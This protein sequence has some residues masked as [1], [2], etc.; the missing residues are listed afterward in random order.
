MQHTCKHAGN[1]YTYMHSYIHTNIHTYK[2]TYIQACMQHAYVHTYRCANI[3]ACC[4]HKSKKSLKHSRICTQI[5]R[6]SN[7]LHTCTKMQ[8]RA[9]EIETEST[10]ELDRYCLSAANLIIPKKTWCSIRRKTHLPTSWLSSRRSTLRALLTT[11]SISS[12]R[13][14]SWRSSTSSAR[15]R[16]LQPRHSR[17]RCASLLD[18]VG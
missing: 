7:N 14:K 1:T 6:H 15:Q 16:P 11:R 18:R 2:R 8:K 12:P 9:S 17:R 10:A 5:D 3:H 4:M 13:P